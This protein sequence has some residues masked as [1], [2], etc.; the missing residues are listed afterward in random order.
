MG[1]PYRTILFYTCSKCSK[2]YEYRCEEKGPQ[3]C[4]DGWL[5]VNLEAHIYRP[6]GNAYRDNNKAAELYCPTCVNFFGMTE[7]V[8]HASYNFVGEQK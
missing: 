8:R 2:E 6:T 5:K 3:F 7:L 4:Q 1:K